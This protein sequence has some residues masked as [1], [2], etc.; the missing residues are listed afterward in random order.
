KD[1]AI[2]MT[3]FGRGIILQITVTQREPRF[4]DKGYLYWGSRIEGLLWELETPPTREQVLSLYPREMVNKE[5][6]DKVRFYAV[7]TA[8][9]ILVLM[10]FPVQIETAVLVAFVII[11]PVILI[12]VL[13]TVD[14]WRLLKAAERRGLG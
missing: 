8:A 6:R 3:A 5:I 4:K 1:M 7:V 10:A 2:R 14:Y 13:D 9:L 11:A 12:G